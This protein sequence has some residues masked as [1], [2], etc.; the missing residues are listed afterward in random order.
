[1]ARL[2]DFAGTREL[3]LNLTLR[4][5]RGRYKRSVLGWTWS[6]LNPLATVA[7]YTIVFSFFLKI[8]PPVGDPSGLDTFALFLICALVPWNFFSNGINGSMGSLLANANLIKKVYFPRELLVVSTIASL[9]V[10]LGIELGVV[11]VILL[12]VGNMV[13]PWIPV[14]LL[15]MAIQ[16]VFVLGI[17]LV[18]STCNVYYR[19]IQHLVGILLQVLFYLTPIVYP[20]SLVP[21]E[22]DVWGYEIPVRALYELNPLVT[23]VEA[24]R[25]VLYDLR[26]PPIADWA[27]MTG[28][29]L[30]VAGIG[31][32]V[33][34][35]LDRRLAEEV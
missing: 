27:Y 11:C 19:D 5:L 18:L 24:Y 20:M 26:F 35:K 14:L 10:T 12:V 28:W 1:M 7:I 31:M 32:W 13:I 3:T 23:F 21:K 9:V 4:E 15:L 30:A 6:L 33:F 2:A 8:E 29:A 22:A 16:T 25:D 34:G 17:G